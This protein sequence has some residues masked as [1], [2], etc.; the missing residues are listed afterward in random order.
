M[1]YGG[2]GKKRKLDGGINGGGAVQ[3]SEDDLRQ[4]LVPLSKDQL[5]SL[6][7][8]A[9]CLYPAVADDI[10]DVASKDPAHRK[11]F[12]RGLAWETGSL[13]LREAFEKYGEVEEGAVII[14]KSTGKSRGF[15][16]ITFKHMDSAQRALKEPSKTIDGRITVCN[17]ATAGTNPAQSADQSQRKLYIGGLSYETSNETLISLFSQYGEIEEGSVA[18]DKN[19][20]KSRGFAFVTFKTAEAANKALEDTNR[21]LDGRAVTVKLAIEGQKERAASQPAPPVQGQLAPQLQP[22][23]GTANPKFSSYPRPQPPGAAPRA[24]PALHAYAAQPSYGAHP[25]YGHTF[26]AQPAYTGLSVPHG[27]GAPTQYNPSSQY[28]PHV[29]FQ[30]PQAAQSG[31]PT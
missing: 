14:D 10:R 16:F 25:L 4:L 8:N 3:P 5:V 15:G 12:V 22:G 2:D 20:N 19:T 13:T 17:L 24:Y 23:Y 29:V 26:A 9:G 21:N 6:L 1:E 7:V 28:T 31:I 11:L 27:A 18:Y 30:T